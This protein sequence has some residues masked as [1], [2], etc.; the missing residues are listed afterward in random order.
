MN[1]A[2]RDTLLTVCVAQKTTK[3]VMQISILS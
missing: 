1:D 3:E 2:S